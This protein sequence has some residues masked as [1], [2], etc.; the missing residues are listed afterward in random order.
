MTESNNQPLVNSKTLD[1]EPGADEAMSR[2]G[3]V[4]EVVSTRTGLLDL[5]PEIRL[6]IFR[7]LLVR[8]HSLPNVWPD[9]EANSDDDSDSVSDHDSLSDHD[10]DSVS[11]HDSL[12]DHEFYPDLS[13][14]RTSKL[15]HREAFDVYYKENRFKATIESILFIFQF[16]RIVNIM[17]NIET[18]LILRAPYSNSNIAAFI[19]LMQFFGNHSVIRGNLVLELY[20]DPSPYYL[21]WLVGALGRFTN[22]RMI[23]LHLYFF[24]PEAHE[25]DF[26]EWCEHLK[27]ALEP[28]LGY[29][30]E[31]E[32]SYWSST[33]TGLRFHP[34]DH[35]NQSREPDDGD[36]EYLD[37]IRLAW[38]ET[39]TDADD[40]GTGRPN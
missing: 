8:P 25:N 28:V 31:F 22:F 12:S 13:I 26:L 14:L 7:H 30:E 21:K 2:N 16:P 20:I 4:A 11:D 23:S 10:S 38:K 24:G 32:A 29:A 5:P 36:C 15:I 18:D 34:V 17:Q 35:H 33:K 1:R 6:I 19:K 3:A 9:D 40:C 27:T 39:P 37:G